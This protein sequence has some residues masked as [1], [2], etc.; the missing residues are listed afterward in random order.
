VAVAGEETWTK[1]DE[2]GWLLVNVILAAL[3]R[4]KPGK[5]NWIGYLTPAGSGRPVAIQALGSETYA[6]TSH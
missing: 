5:A 4:L 6:V 1:D 3:R 2:R